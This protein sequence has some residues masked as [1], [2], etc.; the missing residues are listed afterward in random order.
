MLRLGVNEGV[1]S[2]SERERWRVRSKGKS[3]SLAGEKR[4]IAKEARVH[5]DDWRRKP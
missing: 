2:A 4:S 5:R 1:V 3:E